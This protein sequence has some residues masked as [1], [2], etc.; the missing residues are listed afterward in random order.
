MLRRLPRHLR[1]H[2]LRMKALP[3]MG[4]DAYDAT[5]RACVHE[6]FLFTKLFY[7][8]LC[9]FIYFAVVGVAIELN[10]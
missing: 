4:Y 5:P 2:I 10:Q 9:E 8:F 1:R 6:V 3:Y 7:E